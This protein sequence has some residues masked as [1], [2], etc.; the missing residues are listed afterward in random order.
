MSIHRC[1]DISCSISDMGKMAS[2]SSGVTGFRVWGLMTGASGPGMSGIMLYHCLGSC[3][4]F[5][6]IL[7]CMPWAPLFQIVLDPDKSGFLADDIEAVDLLQC[8]QHRTLA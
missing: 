6:R 7:V 1:G 8:C 5:R 3:S 4:S 2:M